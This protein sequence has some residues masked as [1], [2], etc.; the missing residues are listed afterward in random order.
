M[1]K[2]NV[3]VYI[4]EGVRI[5]HWFTAEGCVEPGEDAISVLVDS[6]YLGSLCEGVDYDRTEGSEGV[7]QGGNDGD[8]D[9][10]ASGSGANKE[11][12][13]RRQPTKRTRKPSV[14]GRH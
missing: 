1:E 12:V 3:F 7:H 6:S 10:P 11:R 4:K 8:G 14:T 5:E 13:R 9:S 2:V